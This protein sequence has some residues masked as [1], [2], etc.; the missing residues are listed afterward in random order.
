VITELLGIYSGPGHIAYYDSHGEMR[1]ECEII[2]TGRPESGAPE[3]DDEA[4]DFGWFTSA[5]LDGLDIH[6][7]QRR[8][9]GHWLGGSYPHFDSAWQRLGQ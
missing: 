9:L 8:Q 3:V 2:F 7:T 5:E 6:P 1:Q 4:S